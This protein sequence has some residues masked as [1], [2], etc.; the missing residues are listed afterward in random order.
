MPHLAI[1][2]L[3]PLRV[4]LD[5]KP[6]Q[7]S[8]HKALALLVY[9]AMNRE[10]Q[11]RKVLSSL[12]W[13]EYEQEKAYA[14]L[15]R[16]LW[17]LNSLLGEGWLEA[18]REEISLDFQA[19]VLL[20][21][22]EFQAHLVALRKHNHTALLVDCQDCL[23]HL[24]TVTL[25]YR[26]DFLS[27]F[28]LRDSPGYE[29]W[30]FFQAENLRRE[31][32]S[33]LQKLA[34]LLFQ[35]SSFVEAAMFAQRWLALDNL[36]EE[37]HRLL[38]KIFSLG[39]QR[40]LAIRQYQD[41]QRILQKELGVAPEPATRILHESISSGEVIQGREIPSELYINWQQKSSGED[42]NISL[43]DGA[44]FPKKSTSTIHLPAPPTAF[45]GRDP[46]LNRISALLS[47]PGC[48]L[49]TLLGPGG[50]GKTRLAIEAGQIN[51]A[52]FPEGVIF[53]P[54]S[55]IEAD[56]SIAPT[57]ASAIGLI[58]RQ[59]G[60][61]P[62]EQLL[63][64]LC[65]K[66]LLLIFDAFEQL[67]PW[68]DFLTRIHSFAPGIK[69][70]VTSRHRLLLH[71]E[72]VMEVKGLNYPLQPYDI[73]NTL[74][75]EAF[76]SYSALE[77][78][79][80][81]I[82]R[83]RVDFQATS[84]DFSA[85]I[86]IA[87][88]VE[89]MPLCLELA[90]TWI[91]TLSCQ[92]IAA[93][94]IRG[95]DILE[96][97]SGTTSERQRS[98]RAIFDHSWK[99][100]SRREQMILPR[101]A[102]F[103]GSFSRQAA[104]QIAGVSLH[105]ISCLVD[106]S[107]VRRATKGRFDLHDLLRQY[108]IGILEQNP[109]DCQETRHRHSAF[110]SSRLSGWNELLKGTNQ[111]QVL[112]DI[113]TD[114]ENC[115]AAWEWALSHRQLDI[116]E[117]AI[118]GLG[119]FLMR[120]ALL[121]EGWE[122]CR[123]VNAVLQDNTMLDESLLL[124]RLSAKSLIWQ[125]VFCINLGRSEEADQHLHQARQVLNQALFDPSQL[126]HEQIFYLVILA[127]SANLQHKP[128]ATVNY[129]EQACELSRNA[130]A[131]PPD[132]FVFHWRFLMSGSVSKEL[133]ITIK[134]D[135]EDQ[136]QIENP[137][138][139]G[140]VLFTL[141]IAELFH[142]SRIEKAEPLLK[143]CIQNFQLVDDRS[144]QDIILKT[145][146][147][148]L[149]VQGK[150]EE[151]LSVKQHELLIVKDLGDPLLIGT[152][153]AEIGEVLYHQGKFDEAEVMLCKGMELIK[154]QREGEYIFRLSYLAN[155]FLAQG[156]FEQ[157]LQAFQT[158][159]QFF[160][161]VDEKGWMFTTLTGLSRTEFALGDRSNA[162]LHATQAIQL[163]SEIQLFSF[164]VY[165]TLANIALLL[166]ERGEILKGLEL[167]YF[168]TQQ[169]YLAQSRWFADLFGRFFEDASAGVSMEEQD[170]VKKS[171]LGLDFSVAIKMVQDLISKI[172]GQ[173]PERG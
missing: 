88:L 161:S 63:D 112:Q 67:V 28:R 153:D 85:M 162:W 120:R 29:D 136:N 147:Y 93:E 95:L 148:L 41:C 71:G 50:I 152:V 24:Q 37:A 42:F 87:Q 134:K 9:L 166:V 84:E 80:L 108:C 145:L 49:L 144:T 65:S 155:V 57:I 164:F 34:N 31:Y 111:G 25:L 13:P 4:E 167:Y 163:Y 12:L 78:F 75:P 119:M 135:F 168:T 74:T 5:G 61:P 102:V 22:S 77:L 131:R 45:I 23:A 137:F 159:Y 97:T 43:M 122:T 156:K 151:C 126:V 96:L 113:E 106:K 10:K 173:M 7:T 171:G 70:L 64:F 158:C 52:K 1:F 53:I 146:S 114:L 66:H 117:Q 40:H 142:F 90:A 170:T 91:N 109:I 11:S 128:D 62:E 100:L 92:E 39:G 98:M 138:E 160:R 125:A 127:W 165:L 3:G 27:G 132:F 89:G 36:N 44:Y 169:G 143:E 8:R 121:D 16:T 124:I 17:E 30:Q 48:W 129:Y 154:S 15:R 55:M 46:E 2:A 79:Q 116:L 139:R 107:L 59:E 51:S 6:I 21:V 54:L 83:N 35:K 72:W 60:A 86:R 149:L 140:C 47:D 14:Y 150:F 33:S 141:G 133:Y 18:S 110:Y 105:D 68:A 32:A 130:Q 101:L 58:F 118:D 82:R 26:G 99:L 20:D 76:E 56:R 123:K 104:E 157:A 73:T 38:M 94:I 103:Q 172:N 69:L 81:A 115:K 19:N